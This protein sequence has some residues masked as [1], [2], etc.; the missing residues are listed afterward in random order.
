[1]SPDGDEV[2]PGRKAEEPAGLTPSWTGAGYVQLRKRSRLGEHAVLLP[3]GLAVAVDALAVFALIIVTYVKLSGAPEIGCN[4]VSN[5]CFDNPT[6]TILAAEAMLYTVGAAALLTIVASL[7]LRTGVL[8][9]TV[10][11]GLV[12]AVLLVHTIPEI[13]HAETARHRLL[14]C[15]Y[16]LTGSCPGI[17][18][19]SGR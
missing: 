12:I 2:L 15:N 7:V 14:A 1:M 3:F 6:R 18:T 9:V 11:Q 19:Y 4:A 10:I 5:V 16:A 17:Q 13:S 8:T